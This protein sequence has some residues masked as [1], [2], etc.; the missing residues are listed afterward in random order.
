MAKRRFRDSIYHRKSDGRWC[1]VINLGWQDG[2]RIRKNFYG[3]T[4]DEV[5]KQLDAAR[6]TLRKGLPVRLDQQ[7]VGDYLDSWLTDSVKPSVRPLT[8]QLY[9]QHAR[10]YLKPSLGT[11][12]LANL[13]PQHIRSFIN[14]RLAAGLHPRTVQLSLIVLRKALAQAAEDN[15][16]PTNAAK[17]VKA[18]HYEAKEVEPWTPEQAS[19]FLQ[20]AAGERFE[21]CF[22]IALSLGLRCGEA[23]AL[24]WPDVNLIERRLTVA[25]QLVRVGGP[26]VDGQPGRLEFAPVKTKKAR[27]TLPL[28]DSLVGILKAHHKRQLKQR[29]RSGPLWTDLDLLFCTSHGK[30]LESTVMTKDFKRI[31][32]KAGLPDK[33]FHDCRHGVATALLSENTHPRL[34]MELLGHSNVN[35]TLGTYSHAIEKSMRETVATM[36][37]LINSR[38]N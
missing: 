25:Q 24:R 26:R 17:P 37:R 35:V 30:P 9:H 38:Q 15:L 14:A 34:V 21:A 3:A 16:V 18:P 10:L 33:R 29:L 1:A 36:D 6:E 4:A 5:Q 32:R 12:K 7:N 20:T 22:A 23:L 28:P 2:K 31:S 11:L 13:S 8:F 19:L 27:R